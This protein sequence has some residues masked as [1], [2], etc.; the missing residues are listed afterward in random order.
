MQTHLLLELAVIR[1][2]LGARVLRRCPDPICIHARRLPSAAC[3]NLP[4]S[5]HPSTFQHLSFN[6]SIAITITNDQR[7]DQDRHHR[8]NATPASTRAS[9]ASAL[10]A[11]A[12]ASAS[13]SHTK[14]NTTISD[15]H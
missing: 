11:S 7:Q 1:V 6:A 9:T 3:S 5:T 12:S 15:Q 4:T 8:P 14:A 2:A 13:A 10:T